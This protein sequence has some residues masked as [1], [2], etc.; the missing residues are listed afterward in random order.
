MKTLYG[1][2]IGPGDPDLITLKGVKLIKGAASIFVPKSKTE[3][4]A[5]SIA[6]EFLEGKSVIEISFPMGKDNR[7]RYIKAAA[8]IDS[9]LS[10]GEYGVFLTL[11]DPL[12]Y[13]TFIYI[14]SEVS[15]LGIKVE[16]VPGITSFAAAASL[17]MDPLT[18]KNQSFYLADGTVDEEI[19]SRVDSVCVLKTTRNKEETLDKLEAGGFSYT[20]IKRCTREGELVLTDRKKILEDHDYMS[21]ILAKRR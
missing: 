14:M 13:S 11:G 5:G 21:L 15:K 12:I 4:L 2:G 8:T 6:A 16:T 19:L 18:L 3:S 10:D 20:Y 1:V 17:I 9:K 7:E